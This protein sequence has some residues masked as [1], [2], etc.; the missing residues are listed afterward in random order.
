MQTDARGALAAAAEL[1]PF[2]AVATGPT[3]ASGLRPVRDLYTD[4][5]PLRARLAHVEAVL[6]SDA[7]T[8][9]SIT[10][11]GLA[12]RVLSAPLAAAMLCGTVPLLTPDVLHFRVTDDK[13]WPLWCADPD[14]IAVP[15][16]AAAAR[17]LA[18]LLIDPHLAPLV[19]AVR[20]QVAVSPRLLWGNVASSVAAGKRLVAAH[21][22]DVAERAAAI[23]EHLLA[24]GSLQGAGELL[25]PRPPDHGWT[26]RRHSC[27]LYY[28]VP[29]GGLCGDCAL[30]EVPRRS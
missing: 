10:F 30:D 4:P 27:C 13:P 26:F 17:A 21:R 16:A 18:E 12:A 15:D 1:G 19:A 24:T 6:G 8:A 9:A 29:G 25:P 14:A 7:R 2:F 22:P 23:A 20:A 11:Q 3:D 5:G 28:R